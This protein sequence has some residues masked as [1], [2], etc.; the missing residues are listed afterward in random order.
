MTQHLI[1]SVAE[2]CLNHLHMSRDTAAATVTRRDMAG[3]GQVLDDGSAD[4]HYT[5][6]WDSIWSWGGTETPQVDE[7]IVITAGQTILL[8]TSTPILAFLLID[9][10]KLMYDREAD[11]LNLQSKYILII[12]GGALEI[13]TEDEPYLNQASITMHG[14]VRC[15]NIFLYIN[16][17]Y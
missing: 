17:K 7:F 14:N 4:L 12:N 10:G 6:R 9:G 11:G 5:D 16:I 3:Y 13:G 2:L 8:D 1:Q 15:G